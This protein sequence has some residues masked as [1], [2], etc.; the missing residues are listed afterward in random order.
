MTTAI[1][2]HLDGPRLALACLIGGAVATGWPVLVH[3]QAHPGY[4]WLVAVLAVALYLPLARWDWASL[5]LAAVPQQGWGYWCRLAAILGL[6]V[7][8]L[9]AAGVGL[10]WALGLDP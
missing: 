10:R 7:G 2:R 5:G 6:A 9:M 1:G 8:G 4:Q 3:A